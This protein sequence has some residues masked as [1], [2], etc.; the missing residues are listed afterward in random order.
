M[1]HH[2]F[3]WCTLECRSRPSCRSSPA[4]CNRC[5]RVQYYPTTNLYLDC[6]PLV[7]GASRGRHWTSMKFC[8][9]RMYDGRASLSETRARSIPFIRDCHQ[10]QSS[11]RVTAHKCDRRASVESY[12]NLKRKFTIS[13]WPTQSLYPRLPN[14]PAPQDVV[15]TQGPCRVRHECAY[16]HRRIG[17]T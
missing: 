10:Y 8:N 6:V 12:C 14:L 5:A 11:Q 4:N 7:I 16:S 1:N 13:A 9:W 15:P 2:N 17:L 3:A